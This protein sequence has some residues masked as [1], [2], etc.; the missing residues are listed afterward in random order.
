MSL[1]GISMPGLSASPYVCVSV[2]YPEVASLH[3]DLVRAHPELYS[4]DIRALVYLGELWSAKN[5]VDA[6]RIRGVLRDRLRAITEPYDAVLTP[7]AA[8]QPP[9][10]GEKAQVEGDPPGSELYTFMRF[11][12]ALNVTGYPAISLPA[13]LDRDGLPVGLQVIG[14]PRAD[15]ALLDVAQ[16]IETVLGV[17]PAA[18]SVS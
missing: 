3:H 16:R 13:G 14:K 15:T 10:I 17:M 2:V 18:P 9:R 6:Q 4:S 1:K 11:T 7:T 12:V 5:Y 8:I